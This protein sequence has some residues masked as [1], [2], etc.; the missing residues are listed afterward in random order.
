MSVTQSAY[1][2]QVIDQEHGLVVKDSMNEGKKC[3]ER[4][5]VNVNNRCDEAAGSG[6][7]QR[8]YRSDARTNERCNEGRVAINDQWT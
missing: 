8:F 4:K 5:N 2:Q 3:T 1:Q 7:C 6:Q